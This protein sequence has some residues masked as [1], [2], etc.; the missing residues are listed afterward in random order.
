MDDLGR[1]E[2]HGVG[3]SQDLHCGGAVTERPDDR[4]PAERDGIRPSTG[5]LE[6]VSP[7]SSAASMSVPAG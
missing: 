3:L 4:R 2:P 1:G 7:R 6:F 5:G